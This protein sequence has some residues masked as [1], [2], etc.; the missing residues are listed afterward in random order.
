MKES[1]TIFLIIILAYN[2]NSQ[3]RIK[4][5]NNVPY[6]QIELNFP[7]G[8]DDQ[9][10]FTERVANISDGE[11]Y[12]LKEE[13]DTIQI[14][15]IDNSN[16]Q[17]TYEIN[18]SENDWMAMLYEEKLFHL[19]NENISFPTIKYIKDKSTKTGIYPDSCQLSEFTAHHLQN[20]IKL[21]KEIGEFRHVETYE[22]L[23]QKL[24][25][26]NAHNYNYL[27]QSRIL[28]A[29]DNYIIPTNHDTLKYEIIQ[30]EHFGVKTKIAAYKTKNDL[31]NDIIH[32]IQYEDQKQNK[33]DW[34]N[35]IE[36]YSD[37]LDEQQIA[38]YLQVNNS[39]YSYNR[40]TIEFDE[41]QNFI[42]YLSRI[43]RQ[44]IDKSNKNQFRFYNYEIIKI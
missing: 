42:K 17:I 7:I 12:W 11:I 4:L 27:Q 16:S 15:C 29:I 6:K 35:L 38:K 44:Y 8:T 22:K 39:N 41:N 24:D 36:L 21:L 14:K 18:E 1:L 3:E 37:R 40:A 25:T 10:V 19:I 5:L 20:R 30:L 31:G 33:K 28:I 26:C 9:Y 2:G 43:S 34:E 13:V 23:I 32:L